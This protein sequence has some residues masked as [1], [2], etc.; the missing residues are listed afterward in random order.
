MTLPHFSA[1]FVTHSASMGL[2]VCTLMTL[3]SIPSAE[4]SLAASS[5]SLTIKPQANTAASLPSRSTLA[6]PISKG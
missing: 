1:Y 3:I 5:A 2:M 6:L 4:S